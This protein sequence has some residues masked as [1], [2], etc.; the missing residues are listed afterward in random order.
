MM[1]SALPGRFDNKPV[2]PICE[3]R[4][5]FPE[6]GVKAL[7]LW[8][9]HKAQSQPKPV[10]YLSM[11]LCHTITLARFKK[12]TTLAHFPPLP[13]SPLSHLPEPHPP[14]LT[15]QK[16]LPHPHHLP[17]DPPYSSSLK[18]KSTSPPTPPPSNEITEKE[19]TNLPFPTP[20]PSATNSAPT[21]H[22]NAKAFVMGTVRDNSADPIRRKNH[23]LPVMFMTN[24]RA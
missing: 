2:Y 18:P 20:L 12:F 1:C 8:T 15:P 7:K 14:I 24:G 11:Y 21:V 10:P 9:K 16:P 5:G 6:R 22:R 4:Y 13:P 23:M 3:Y 17:H 19:K